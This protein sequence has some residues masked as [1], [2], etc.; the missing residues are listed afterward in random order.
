VKW[1]IFAF[2]LGC[3]S[4]II[5][6]KIVAEKAATKW[7]DYL[8]KGFFEKVFLESSP[9]LRDRLNKSK[10][11]ELLTKRL[12]LVGKNKVRTKSSIEALKKYRGLGGG[13]FISIDYLS[14]FELRGSVNERVV[15]KKEGANWRVFDYF[16]F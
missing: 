8:D 2:F 4:N 1:L 14:D 9:Y 11:E 7:F 3:S 12:I 16:F 6:S 13:E 10:L 5:D 15:L